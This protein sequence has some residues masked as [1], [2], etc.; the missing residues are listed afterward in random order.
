M[1]ETT[2]A[3]RIVEQI[4]TPPLSSMGEQQKTVGLIA[5][6][7]MLM[8]D[9]IASVSAFLASCRRMKAYLRRPNRRGPILRD[10]A[11]P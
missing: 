9:Q 11:A 1:D 7:A 5:A 3:K 8:P 2:Q 4:G 10:T 6:D